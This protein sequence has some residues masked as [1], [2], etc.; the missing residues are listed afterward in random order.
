MG[1]SL[2]NVTFWPLGP[3][4]PAFGSHL[5]PAWKNKIHNSIIWIIGRNPAIL[6]EK[7]THGTGVEPLESWIK[8]EVC[9]EYSWQGPRNPISPLGWVGLG[10]LSV[11]NPTILQ[12]SL[13]VR[14]RKI[15]RWRRTFYRLVGH[16]GGLRFCIVFPMPFWIDF[17]VQFAS[18]LGTQ[19]P[20]KSFQM[21]T[22]ILSWTP[23][24]DRFLVDVCSQ[25]GP[26]DPEKKPP[27]QP[28]HNFWKI[29]LP[30]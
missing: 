26:P 10:N 12:S 14:A 5:P 21:Q 1:S 13:G 24:L 2:R 3:D 8:L 11:V 16:L 20:P 29:A 17:L 7:I 9:P 15:D 27:L 4:V 18:Q 25:L 28:D 22:C 23:F 30:S 6:H 19:N